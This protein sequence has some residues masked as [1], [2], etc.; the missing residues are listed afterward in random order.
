MKALEQVEAKEQAQNT[1][2]LQQEVSQLEIGLSTPVQAVG[3]RFVEG[4]GRNGS[5]A[6]SATA[7][8]EHDDS[9]KKVTDSSQLQLHFAKF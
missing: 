9:G 1:K 3:P 8:A 6:R 2:T 4:R 5:E 7:V